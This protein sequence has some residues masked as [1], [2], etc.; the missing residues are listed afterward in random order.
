MKTKMR[1]V[2]RTVGLLAALVGAAAGCGDFGLFGACVWDPN[3]SCENFT[4]SDWCAKT[5]GEFHAGKSC[6]EVAANY[7]SCTP[8]LCAPTE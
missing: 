1:T 2:S 6:G 4:T 3:R 7:R 5:L 8:P